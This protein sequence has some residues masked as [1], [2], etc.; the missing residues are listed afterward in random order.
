MIT[1]LTLTLESDGSLSP[2]LNSTPLGGEFEIL[3]WL[4]PWDYQVF[5]AGPPVSPG[6][7]GGM[8]GL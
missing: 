6:G 4:V 2:Q 3:F 8:G 1:R 5:A 7:Q